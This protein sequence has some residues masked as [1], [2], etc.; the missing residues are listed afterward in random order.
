[1]KSAAACRNDEGPQS[2]KS[3]VFHGIG[4][5]Q[6]FVQAVKDVDFELGIDVA[7]VAMIR[8]YME[9]QNTDRE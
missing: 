9:E 8:S 3:S 2:T 4:S 5:S 1:M 6:K 7:D